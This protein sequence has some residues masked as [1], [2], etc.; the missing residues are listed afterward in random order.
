M[1][2]PTLPTSGRLTEPT[3]RITPSNKSDHISYSQI[4]SYCMCS[5]KWYFSRHFESVSV[6][7]ALVFGKS[8]HAAVEHYYQEHM[9][10]VTADVTQLFDVFSSEYAEEKKPII[11]GKTE[12]EDI[13]FEKAQQMLKV[14]CDNVI[15]G[16]V[17][18]I[19]EEIR[20]TLQQDM[21]ELLGYIDLIEIC[22]NDRGEDE[23]VLVD[24]KTTARKPAGPGAPGAPDYN[25]L[26]LYAIAAHKLNLVKQY[27][28]PL[29]LRFDYITKTKEPSYIQFRFEPDHNKARRLLATMRSCCRGMREGIIFPNPGWQC[30]GCGYKKL[31]DKWPALSVSTPS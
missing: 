19:E 13:L 11:Y 8:W 10:G 27:N 12:S 3:N 21:P 6:S 20:C 23:L 16:K 22:K 31:C 28:L 18:A 9:Q 2:M 1:I 7:S 17:V 30:S 26:L 14:F 24:H 29:R 5:L 25:Q 15:P 4:K